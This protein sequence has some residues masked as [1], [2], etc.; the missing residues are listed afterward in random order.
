MQRLIKLDNEILEP[1]WLSM[2]LALDSPFSGD[3][4]SNWQHIGWRKISTN[5]QAP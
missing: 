1:T 5:I 4:D 3:S 2:M